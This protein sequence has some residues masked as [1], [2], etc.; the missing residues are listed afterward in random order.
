MI[1]LR[2]VTEV[3]LNQHPDAKAPNEVQ[4][5]AIAILTNH[6]LWDETDGDL[7]IGYRYD[8]V[9]IKR[10]PKPSSPSRT[11]AYALFSHQ[12]LSKEKQAELELMCTGHLI[13]RKPRVLP[14]HL[15][16]HAHEQ[17]AG[18]RARGGGVGLLA[19]AATPVAE[20]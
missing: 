12:H 5:R 13:P 15:P 1:F 3:W 4:M 2:L 11:Y 7:G 17:L 19:A 8:S 20:T 10:C 6:V 9:R 16:Q 14:Q 18:T